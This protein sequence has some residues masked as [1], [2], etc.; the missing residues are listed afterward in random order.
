[1]PQK[2]PPDAQLDERFE[3]AHKIGLVIDHLVDAMGG[4]P[5]SPLRR[6]LVLVD[7]DEHPGTMQV[8]IMKRVQIDKSSLNRDVEWLYDHGCVV[9]Q[10]SWDDARV[11]RLYTVGYTKK[12]LGM[13]LDTFERSY[14]NLK[15]FIETYITLFGSHK[16]TLRD[17]KIVAAVG[18]KDQVKKQ[19]V[20]EDLYNGPLTTDTRAITLLAELGII[21]KRNA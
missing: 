12:H 10:Q 11:T 2:K 8:D 4:D 19:D 13:V 21:G 6:A 16:P 1:M 20:L 9:R 17:A 15:L 5:S 7:I 14:K 3:N 18:E